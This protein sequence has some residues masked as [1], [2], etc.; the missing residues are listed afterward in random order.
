MLSTASD[1]VLASLVVGRVDHKFL[2]G[3]VIHSLCTAA[4]AAANETDQ[5][6]VRLTTRKLGVAAA[7]PLSSPKDYEVA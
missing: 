5:T 6:E 4:V 7:I 3:S 1:P 2:A